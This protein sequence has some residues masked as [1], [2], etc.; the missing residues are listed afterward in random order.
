[1][2]CF[3]IMSMTTGDHPRP[4]TVG[5]YPTRRHHRG[6]ERCGV[7]SGQN[8]F[9][10]WVSRD[11]TGQQVWLRSVVRRGR[12]GFGRSRLCHVCGLSPSLSS[13]VVWSGA[14]GW[15]EAQPAVVGAGELLLPDG[16]YWLIIFFYLW[17][18][19][20]VNISV[21][22]AHSPTA[23]GLQPLLPH[24]MTQLPISHT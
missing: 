11:P 7:P 12:E 17:W 5:V 6:L 4:M 19:W 22:V 24:S 18:S 8:H 9:S 21:L 1:M 3:L 23:L 10:H 20:P 14:A 15:G 16:V 2:L 13:V